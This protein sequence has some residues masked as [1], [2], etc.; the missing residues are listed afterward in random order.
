MRSLRRGREACPLTVD[1]PPNSEPCVDELAAGK[2]VAEAPCWVLVPG[3]VRGEPI[4]RADCSDEEFG[5]G[6]GRPDAG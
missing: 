1:V 4:M 2:D 5:M 6:D 3:W